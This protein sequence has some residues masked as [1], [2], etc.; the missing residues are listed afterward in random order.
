[1]IAELAGPTVAY[2]TDG[3]GDLFLAAAGATAALS[4]LIFV[5]LS[6]NLKAVLQAD[7]QAGQN[8]L[9]GRAIEALV[10][11]LIVLVISLVA[12]TPEIGRGILA[13][14][15]LAT[16]VS[17]AISPGLLLMAGHRQ[18]ALGVGGWG[19]LVMATTLTV[20]LL[21]AGTTLA[22]GAGGGL[23]WLPAA[24]VLAIAIAAVNAWILLVEILR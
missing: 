12:L 13:A 11:L 3:W 19:R 20:T 15:V 24:F 2:S 4:G 10:D 22:A 9:T 8:F 5:G 18:Q 23:Y 14:F 17:S 1:M 7:R 21:L 16:A 6:V